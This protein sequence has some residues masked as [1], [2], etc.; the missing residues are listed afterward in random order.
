MVL[1]GNSVEIRPIV[2]E[3]NATNLITMVLEETLVS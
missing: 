2:L 3:I 1:V